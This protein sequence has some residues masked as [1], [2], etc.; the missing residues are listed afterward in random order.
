MS[1]PTRAPGSLVDTFRIEATRGRWGLGECYDAIDT[2]TDRRVVLKVLPGAVARGRARGAVVERLATIGRL[3]QTTVIPVIAWGVLDD[4]PWIAVDPPEGTSLA[5]MIRDRAARRVPLD[6]AV[7][8]RIVDRV[9]H[10]VSAAHPHKPPAAH[11]GLNPESVVLDEAAGV[12]RGARLMDFGLGAIAPAVWSELPASWDPRPPEVSLARRDD[13]LLGDVFGLAVLALAALAVDPT[14]RGQR[15]WAE[16][17]TGRDDALRA[18]IA[19][20][21]DDLSPSLTQALVTALQRPRALKDFDGARRALNEADWSAHL[22]PASPREAPKPAPAPMPAEAAASRRSLPSALR[23]APAPPGTPAPPPPPPPAPAPA[24]ATR[25]EI[26][27][28]NDVSVDTTRLDTAVPPHHEA[29]TGPAAT[30]PTRR[31]E[32]TQPLIDLG[33]VDGAPRPDATRIIDVRAPRPLV[34]TVDV[35]AAMG[36]AFDAADTV[37]MGARHAAPE[38]M[39]VRSL[40]TETLDPF[41]NYHPTPPT[42]VDPFSTSMQSYGTAPNGTFAMGRTEPNALDALVAQTPVEDEPPPRSLAAETLPVPVGAWTPAS[43]PMPVPVPVS[44]VPAPE[45][46]PAYAP[47]PAAPSYAP[48][49][50]VAPLHGSVNAWPSFRPPPPPEPLSTLR[51]RETSALID[52]RR[53]AFDRSFVHAAVVGV[54]VLSLLAML[55][56]SR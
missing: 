55:L 19:Q 37:A 10:A 34:G 56:A 33:A 42:A 17:A 40:T 9:A 35:R 39:E 18:A 7:A 16:L 29:P 51:D 36:S 23:F 3:S 12:V 15:P 25:P 14:R 54:L 32:G 13:E 11:G 5:A 28:D 30:P 24:E 38:A 41:A 8:K 53:G 46:S 31:R 27:L 50:G 44:Y 52:D 47:P 21:R 20:T 4:N 49:P 22:R 48:P 45:A 2:T 26:A 1:A 43:A 6:G